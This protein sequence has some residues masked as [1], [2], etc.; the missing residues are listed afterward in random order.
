MRSTPNE[1][2]DTNGAS[3]PTDSYTDLA[4]DTQ[5]DRTLFRTDILSFR[6]TYIRENNDLLSLLFQGGGPGSPTGLVSQGSHRLNTVLANAEYHFG[7]KVTG[8][9]GW[10]NTTGTADALLYPS[11]PL[12]G[13]FNGDPRS[14][15]YIANVSYWPWQNLQLAAQYTGYTRFNGGSTNYDGA[16]RNASSNDTVYL[17]AKIIF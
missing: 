4:V 10:F 1:L 17:D 15:G 13:N 6:A 8:T 2:T 12:N 9:F 16:G 7:N 3:I 14:A 5:I 11:G